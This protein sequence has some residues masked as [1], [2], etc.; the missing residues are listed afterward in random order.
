[1]FSTHPPTADRIARLQQMAVAMGAPGVNAGMTT[2]EVGPGYAQ[3]YS[4]TGYRR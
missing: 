2:G 1:M 3:P 4:Q